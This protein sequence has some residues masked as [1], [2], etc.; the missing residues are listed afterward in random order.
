MNTQNARPDPP[1]TNL[2]QPNPAGN[3]RPSVSPRQFSVNRA[4][5]P[6]LASLAS[7]P[8]PA[9]RGGLG[10]RKPME[11]QGSPGLFRT[12]SWVGLHWVGL[13][14]ARVPVHRDLSW[15]HARSAIA[16]W[17]G[18]GVTDTCRGPVAVLS[19]S[20]SHFKRALSRSCRGPVAVCVCDPRGHRTVSRAWRGHGAGYRHFFWVWVARAWRGHGA[21]VT[22]G[23]GSRETSGFLASKLH[24]QLPVK[25]TP[26]TG[27]LRAITCNLL[28]NYGQSTGNCG[29]STSNLWAI[30]GQ[31]RAIYAIYGQLL[32]I[33]WQSTGNDSLLSDDSLR[34][35][36]VKETV[37]ASFFYISLR[38]DDP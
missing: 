34:S 16:G 31:L 18:P 29:Q 36:L 23:G 35:E 6:G 26:F 21:G 24:G 13:G 8:I 22:P 19:R 12:R 15:G 28:A 17:A 2:V 1:M 10:Q 5:V 25:F 32:A 38:S 3:G 30:Y 37:L 4:H 7:L 14:R 9:W 20:I 11:G 27:N 33:Y